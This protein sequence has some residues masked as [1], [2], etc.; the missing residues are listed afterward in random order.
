MAFLLFIQFF[1]SIYNFHGYLLIL[2]KNK[3]IIH[4]WILLFSDE[5]A[6]HQ[7]ER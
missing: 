7:R 5:M 4:N 1:M 2:K 6:S 3:E